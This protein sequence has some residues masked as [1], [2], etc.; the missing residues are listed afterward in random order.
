MFVYF[1]YPDFSH[2]LPYMWHLPQSLTPIFI[3]HLPVYSIMQCTVTSVS[4]CS[5]VY[6]LFYVRIGYLRFL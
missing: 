6:L 1:Y 4:L 5:V 3:L 2:V